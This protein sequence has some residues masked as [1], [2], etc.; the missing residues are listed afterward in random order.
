M[1]QYFQPFP[2]IASPLVWRGW[3]ASGPSFLEPWP[4]WQLGSLTHENR[5]VFMLAAL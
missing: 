2:K 5:I 1:G 4:F 3:L